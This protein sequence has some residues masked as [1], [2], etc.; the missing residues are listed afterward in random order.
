MSQILCLEFVTK[1]ALQKHVSE[2]R[3]NRSV[4]E[5]D[6]IASS[7]YELKDKVNVFRM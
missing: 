3:K 2:K 7:E 5:S 6:I 4:N 1:E